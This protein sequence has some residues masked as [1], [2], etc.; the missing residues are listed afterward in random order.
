M[1]GD[2]QAVALPGVRLAGLTAQDTSA[3]PAYG[4]HFF[5]IGFRDD[6]G[7]LVW[8]E[9]KTLKMTA[10]EPVYERTRLGPGSR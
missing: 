5:G 1:L 3:A 8:T 9:E 2:L 10:I 7:L 6:R 4:D